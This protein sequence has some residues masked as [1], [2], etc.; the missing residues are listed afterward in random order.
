[1]I[2]LIF[3]IAHWYLA[4]FSQS[5]FDHRYAS[6]RAFTMSKFWE[7]VFYIFAYITQGSSYLSPRAYA[8]MHRMHHA[9]TDTERDPHS[10]KYYSNVFSMMWHTAKIYS[11]IFKGK[12]P[13]EKQFL[14]N[15][16]SWDKFDR[17]ADSFYSKAGWILVYTLF[18][19]FFAT[20]PWLLLLLPL[21][22]LMGPLHGVIINWFAHKYGYVNFTMNNTSRNLM[23][24]DVFML[25]EGYHN[26]HHQHPSNP[27]FGSRW[28]E[29]DP[30]YYI[31]LFLS[32]IGVINLNHNVVKAHA[33]VNRDIAAK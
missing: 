30:V 8:I 25:G 1:M 4:L 27:N 7:R 21:T 3:F 11:S 10:P 12:F 2:I 32:K 6:H 16:P 13:V 19:M 33:A 18:Y 5:F 14:K 15:L 24:V 29:I 26:D 28:F 17:F 31:I 9:Y 23:P 22:I 20:S